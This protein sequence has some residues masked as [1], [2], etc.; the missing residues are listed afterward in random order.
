MNA[1]WIFGTLAAICFFAVFEGL[2]FRWPQRYNTL[3]RAIY[4]IS[5]KWPLSIFLM[6]M[7]CGGLA[8]HFF[9]H[10]CPPGSIGVGMLE[11]PHWV[12]TSHLGG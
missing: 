4:N 6:G 2:A 12:F 1:P 10:W 3:S 7:F 8:V 11:F 9:W 5:A